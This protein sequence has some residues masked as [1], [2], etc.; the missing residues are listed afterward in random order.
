MFNQS[1]LFLFLNFIE[2]NY[3]N[4]GVNKSKNILNKIFRNLLFALMIAPSPANAQGDADSINL[5]GKWNCALLPSKH[6]MP[7]AS[8]D[9]TA[10]RI[11]IAK[12]SD[13][14]RCSFGGI[15]PVLGFS[16]GKKILQFSVAAT[17]YTQFQ[18][19]PEHF[20]VTTGDY[21]VDILSDVKIT[22]SLVLRVGPGHTS[23]HFLDDAFEILKVTR[24]I[25]Y[26]RDYWQMLLAFDKD[27]Y[28]LYSG[29]TYT[30]HFLIDENISPQWQ[31]RLGGELHSKHD[32]L[33]C[34]PYFSFDVKW[35]G[36]LD[37]ASTQNYQAG[38]FVKNKQN[39]KLRVAY[40]HH[41]GY[42]ERGQYY[43]VKKDYNSIGLYL[44]L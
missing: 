34:Y 33:H 13:N 35:K 43:N 38:V 19:I 11:S 6:I 24:S 31:L 44:E 12:I 42:E 18:R 22:N 10:H 36:E 9:E 29:A 1:M 4:F 25:N 7:F 20:I 23:H 8:A 27:F 41:A 17:Y 5:F 16:N 32:Y 28:M 39:K 3:F 21:F 14:Y 30:Y 26:V 2:E 15:F 40:G 37:M